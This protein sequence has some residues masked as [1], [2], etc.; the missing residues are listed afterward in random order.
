MNVFKWRVSPLQAGMR[1]LSFLREQCKDAS[2]VKALKRA[3]DNKCCL[4]NGN[5]ETFSSFE[6]HAGDEVTVDLTETVIAPCTVLY[7]DDA[8]VAI[9]KRAGV[10]TSLEELGIK[11]GFLVHRLDKETSGVLLI[12]KT[13]EVKTCLEALFKE[14]KMRK[15]Y[16]AIVDG[17]M[18]KKEGIIDRAIGKK[19]SYAGQT[20]YGVVPPD[21]GAR[22]ITHF[23]TL[24]LGNKASLVA[25]EPK[26][27]RTHQLRVH[28]Q[29]LSHP[30][31]GDRQYCKKFS[32]SYA[33]KRNLLHAYEVQ[34]THPLTKAPIKIVAPIPSDFKE[35][36]DALSLRFK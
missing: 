20:V 26:T 18:E 7:E 28:L 34:F 14:R 3:I 25:C 12:A 24:C 32:C 5:I 19:G 33:P 36:M 4:V 27:G 1:L 30:I 22:A 17:K 9:H 15:L 35:A 31:L 13:A 11:N 21:E 6:L 10:V 8:L 23:Q 2:S 29:A 16:L